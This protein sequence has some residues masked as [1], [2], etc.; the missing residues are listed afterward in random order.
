MSAKPAFRRKQY[1]IKHGLQFRYIGIVFALA[2]LT[3]I[4]T[5]YTV[6]ATGWTLLGEKLASVYPQG[7]LIYVLKAAN[8]ALI[9][10]LLL[11]SPFIFFLALFFSHKIA[12]PVYKIEKSMAEIARG[13]LVLR[14][15]LRRGD[16]LKDFAEEINRMTE[17]LEKLV[18]VNKGTNSK[19]M[20]G[21]DR[22]K[23][24]AS[25]STLDRIKIESSINE[26]QGILTDLNASLNK[27]TTS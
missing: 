4:I 21:L 27:W 15:K 10:N 13:N 26:L 3:S 1:L 9:R 5:G 12:G 17:A 11:S 19:V 22:L 24:L 18:I 6:F 16:E 20:Q 14:V 8:V 25:E 23:S 2:I 7:R